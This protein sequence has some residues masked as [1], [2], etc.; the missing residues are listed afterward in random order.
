MGNQESADAHASED[1]TSTDSGTTSE[2]E[3][4][5]TG[6]VNEVDEDSEEDAE[7][8]GDEYYSPTST[9]PLSLS[10]GGNE[11]IIIDSSHIARTTHNSTSAEAEMVSLL[12]ELRQLEQLDFQTKR[13]STPS[14]AT[15]NP[16]TVDTSNTLAI[17]SPDLPSTQVT[18]ALPA[19]PTSVTPDEPTAS[20]DVT[21]AVTPTVSTDEAPATAAPIVPTIHSSSIDTTTTPQPQQQQQLPIISNL[22]RRSDITALRTD[23]LPLACTSDNFTHTAADQ[24][25]TDQSSPA[26]PT[27]QTTPTTPTTQTTPTTPTT[28]P[29]RRVIDHDELIKFTPL[30]I[31]VKDDGSL[32]DT[33]PAASLDS[34]NAGGWLSLFGYGTEPPTTPIVEN[35]ED[36]TPPTEPEQDLTASIFDYI[37]GFSYYF[38]PVPS[39]EP[40]TDTTATTTISIPDQPQEPSPRLE[41]D[42]PPTIVEEHQRDDDIKMLKSTV[43]LL[44]QQVKQMNESGWIGPVPNGI[45]IGAPQYGIPSAAPLADLAFP[46]PV[47]C[48]APPPP[49]PPPSAAPPPPPPFIAGGIPLAKPAVSLSDALRKPPTSTPTSDAT[50]TISTKTTTP[51]SKPEAVIKKELKDIIAASDLSD[52]HHDKA[53]TRYI[54]LLPRFQAQ[55][56]LMVNEYPALIKAVPLEPKVALARLNMWE[57]LLFS[58]LKPVEA[59]ELRRHRQIET[60]RYKMKE[61][62]ENQAKLYFDMQEKKRKEAEAEA[63]QK[64]SQV[65]MNA[66]VDQLNAVFARKAA[67]EKK[68]Q[69]EAA[70][71]YAGDDDDDDDDDFTVED[72]D[73]FLM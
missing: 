7:T 50:S 57:T 60:A 46:L 53:V 4:S 20:S 5:G 22:Y 27:T 71:L 39:A 30:S 67:E 70:A 59:K 32:D 19:V 17:P 37:P 9:S 14:P 42:Q 28:P 61:E 48:P 55:L 16:I 41:E 43:F 47:G 13:T 11:P 64:A 73:K 56:E 45:P 63:T 36:V 1:D 49:P 25:P 38:K 2:G 26:T 23:I 44:Q 54:K 29:G 62:I 52:T 6:D 33:S 40:A 34:T 51:K 3:L 68:A 65:G 18:E 15:Q 8:S 24:E 31:P 69:E 72:L 58:K 35:K 12:R 66:V 10:L 21:P